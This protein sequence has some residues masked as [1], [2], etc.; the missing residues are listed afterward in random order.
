MLKLQLDFGTEAQ[1]SD[2]ANWVH[3]ESSGVFM[4]LILSGQNIIVR[5]T[6]ASHYRHERSKVQILPRNLRNTFLL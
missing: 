1:K 2:I 6:Y 4:A 5:L 3:G